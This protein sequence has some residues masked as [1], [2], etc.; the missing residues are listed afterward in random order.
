MPAAVRDSKSPP[1]RRSATEILI[2]EALDGFPEQDFKKYDK[3]QG[4]MVGSQANQASSLRQ[5]GV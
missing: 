5:A 1:G 4:N 2:I 3:I